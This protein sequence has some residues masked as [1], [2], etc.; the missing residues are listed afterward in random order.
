LGGSLYVSNSYVCGNTTVTAN[1]DGATL[2]YWV[3]IYSGTTKL[4]ISSPVTSTGTSTT[5]QR[6]PIVELSDMRATSAESTHKL[7][8]TANYTTYGTVSIG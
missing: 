4:T 8:G 1:P 7:N 6:E 3:V 5:V 2:K